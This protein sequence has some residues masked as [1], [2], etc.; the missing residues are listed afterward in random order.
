MLAII[1]KTFGVRPHTLILID[2]QVMKQKT[3]SYF[4]NFLYYIPVSKAYHD[5]LHEL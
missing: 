1:Y 4:Q 2:R 3:H 5:V